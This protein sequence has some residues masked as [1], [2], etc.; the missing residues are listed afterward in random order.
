M[1]AHPLGTV[2]L[3]VPPGNQQMPHRIHLMPRHRRGDGWSCP[4]RPG[5]RECHRGPATRPEP[6]STTDPSSLLPNLLRNLGPNRGL[7]SRII[8]PR[9][10]PAIRHRLSARNSAAESPRWV[11]GPCGCLTR[12]PRSEP[13]V[14][15][16]TVRKPSANC[17][18]SWLGA[19]IW[20][21]TRSRSV[22]EARTL[23]TCSWPLRGLHHQH[24]EPP[25]RVGLG[26]RHHRES[27]RP[28]PPVRPQQRVRS[29]SGETR[30]IGAIEV[31]AA[32][33]G[34]SGHPHR[35]VADQADGQTA[36]GLRSG[37]R[38]PQRPETAAASPQGDTGHRRDRRH[39]PRGA[40][41]HNLD[42]VK[43]KPRYL[44]AGVPTLAD[45]HRHDPCQGVR[46]TRDG[47]MLGG[48]RDSACFAR[49]RRHD[50]SPG[51]GLLGERLR[52][53]SRRIPTAK[54]P[55]RGTR[56]RCASDQAAEDRRRGRAI[57]KRCCGPARGSARQAHRPAP[58]GPLVQLPGP[59]CGR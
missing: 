49:S 52:L 44:T 43:V 30:T 8:A 45:R 12:R 27:E 26:R 29:P 19:A 35:H 51:H 46:G 33:A 36:T 47:P 50:S 22:S 37:D 53:P 9:K 1:A 15:A 5:H 25:R 34:S 2:S 58:T 7:T 3:T 6:K 24:Q 20:Q 13:G 18:R 38:G 55:R 23:I 56:R 40:A 39:L 57:R 4:R 14:W 21:S 54:S 59:V 28:Q 48:D 17:S 42:T 31:G 41:L 10:L 16:Q 32:G 11:P